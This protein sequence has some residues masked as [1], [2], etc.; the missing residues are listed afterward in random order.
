MK[1]I[2]AL[3]RFGVVAALALV[4]ALMFGGCSSSENRGTDSSAAGAGGLGK[5]DAGTGGT[6]GAK[7][8][9]SV[10]DSYSPPDVATASVGPTAP[11]SQPQLD[12]QVVPDAPVLDGKGDT[13]VAPDLEAG[14]IDTKST[15]SGDGPIDVGTTQAGFDG[16]VDGGNKG[17]AD[18]GTDGMVATVAAIC[19]GGACTINFVSGSDW[20]SYSDDPVSNPNAVAIGPA[21]P[22]CLND[23]LPAN[24][25]VGALSYGIYGSGWEASLASIP[26]ALWIWGAGISMSDQAALVR[27]YFT[28]TV[29]LGTNPSGTLGIAAD[30]YA[31]VYVNGTSVGSIGSVTDSPT[32]AAAQSKLTSFDLTAALKPGSNTITIAA[33]NGPASFAPGCTS[34]ACGYAQ[35]PAG[36]VFGGS[37]SYQ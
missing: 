27:F 16:A 34:S 5:V 8:D 36:T 14:V 28:R 29:T 24:C 31:E 20:A 1:T 30:D 32:A 4:S 3:N 37:L 26:G 12:A 33:Q 15:T 35:N 21:Q 18:S 25:P 22:V 7:A 6:G 17:S 23:G 13:G 9:A 11:D 19:D 10:S 2:Q